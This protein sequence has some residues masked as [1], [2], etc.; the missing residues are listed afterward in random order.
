MLESIVQLAV[1]FTA[2]YNSSMLD[3]YLV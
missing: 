2:Q 3:K 1:S